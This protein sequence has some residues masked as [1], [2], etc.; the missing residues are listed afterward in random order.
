MIYFANPTTGAVEHMK[1][2]TLGYIDTPLQGNAR[3]DDVTWCADNGCFSDAR[4]SEDKWWAWLNKHAHRAGNCAFATA[5]D[6]VGNHQATMIRSLPWLPKIR[7]LGYKAAFVA[8]DGA[9][10]A[11]LPWDQFD[12]LFIGGTNEFK[13]GPAGRAVIAEAKTRGLWVHCG[14]V[15]SRRRFMTMAA[16]GVDSV[17]GT[18]LVFSPAARL[19]E[20]LSWIDEHRN[21][22]AIPI[23]QGTAP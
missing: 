15:N 21:Q 19:K 20:L 5:P 10:P 2:G 23:T 3:P 12:V 6:V 1:T 14:R 7:S 22:T 11:N 8:Q 17:D 9:T 13:L 4:F 18:C 16:L